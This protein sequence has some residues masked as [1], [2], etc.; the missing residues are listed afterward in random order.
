MTKAARPSEF[1]AERTQKL[2]V[3]EGSPEDEL[4]DEG[5]PHQNQHHFFQNTCP[6]RLSTVKGPRKRKVGGNNFPI[7]SCITEGPGSDKRGKGGR[8]TVIQLLSLIPSP[9]LITPFHCSMDN[10]GQS[11]NAKTSQSCEFLASVSIMAQ[12]L[13]MKELLRV[14]LP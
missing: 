11:S 5:S 9:L 7:I 1:K 10:R 6:T 4:T 3:T 12:V 13:I 8:E 2:Q 14:F